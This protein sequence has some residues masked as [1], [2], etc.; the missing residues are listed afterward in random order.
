M[1]LLRGPNIMAAMKIDPGEAGG[2]WMSWCVV[3]PMSRL[4][5][6]YSFLRV[7]LLVPSD[8]FH[9]SRSWFM[10]APCRQGPFAVLLAFL[11]TC[12]KRVS[13]PPRRCL[14]SGLTNTDPSGASAPPPPQGA[15]A[16]K[17]SPS[18]TAT[19]GP[20]RA[21]YPGEMGDRS[22]NPNLEK[23]GARRA[24]AAGQM[25]SHEGPRWE[26][27]TA[28]QQVQRVAERGL[29][30]TGTYGEA[31]S[32]NQ[33]QQPQRQQQQQQHS[34][35]AGR[36]VP[37]QQSGANAAVPSRFRG[38][39]DQAH[40]TGRWEDQ[41]HDEDEAGRWERSERR[42]Y[43]PANRAPMRREH[44]TAYRHLQ[45]PHTS[46][47]YDDAD[48]R[49][50]PAHATYGDGQLRGPAGRAMMPRE[51]SGPSAGVLPRRSDDG[52]GDEE[53]PTGNRHRP[54]PPYNVAHADRAASWTDSSE[55]TVPPPISIKG[56]DFEKEVVKAAALLVAER[57]M[58]AREEARKQS[59]EE[60][61]E[62][63]PGDDDL[64]QRKRTD[65][66]AGEDADTRKRRESSSRS[67]YHGEDD[68]DDR[69]SQKRTRRDKSP[70]GNGRTE[71]RND[72]RRSSNSKRG[73]GVKGKPKTREDSRGRQ[74][75]DSRDRDNS[76]GKHKDKGHDKR[77][78]S[79]ARD[80]DRG[81]SKSRSS[82]PGSS[83]WDRSGGT[84]SS[85]LNTWESSTADTGY[86]VHVGGL[87]FSTT[88]TTLAKRFAAFGDVNGFKVIFNKVSCSTA[89]TSNRKGSKEEKAAVV[90]A[91]SGFA[92]IS[93]DNERGME[94]AVECMDGQK[95]DGHILKVRAGRSE[96]Q[97]RPH[98]LLCS[99]GLQVRSYF[100][101][102]AA[103]LFQECS[104]AAYRLPDLFSPSL[105]STRQVHVSRL[106]SAPA[107]GSI[108]YRWLVCAFMT[109]G[110]GGV[111]II[112]M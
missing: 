89:G 75:T 35:H 106:C 36:P 4:R 61:N 33:R 11:T 13:P 94:K 40:Y 103:V 12:D 55:Y 30:P 78:S 49:N 98:Y 29:P 43:P 79:S 101:V 104:R 39:P 41:G 90:T 95:L 26:R 77:S 93:F 107:Y 51:S 31:Y 2:R 66:S 63:A 102:C 112:R 59:N 16:P 72:D 18:G 85:C 110:D 42:Q 76:R 56:Q 65:R 28:P 23:N 14:I 50:A 25:N 60:Q 46:G 1:I 44:P 32:H 22:I 8:G 81:S 84:D 111:S 99:F 7:T 9:N 45:D 92:F 83:S 37:Q 71:N 62:P 108:P 24:P 87:S 105:L 52:Y 10:C 47:W 82:K 64:K 88:F 69:P 38:E 70:H 58:K 6:L 15:P 34:W 3:Y 100:P 21:T 48:S 19:A 86:F 17:P 97:A 68:D 54:R 57:E 91:S 20:A 73:E 96:W 67:K 53:I 80:K 27:P 74:E 109:L 5:L